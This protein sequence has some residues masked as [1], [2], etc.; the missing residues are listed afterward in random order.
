M[1]KHSVPSLSS[2]KIS[3][4]NRL[5]PINIYVHSISIA[6]CRS[7]ARDKIF[8]TEGQI[9]T[10]KINVSAETLYVPKQ[11]IEFSSP[12]YMDNR[13]PIQWTDFSDDL[14]TFYDIAFQYDPNAEN[15]TYI[16]DI[17]LL[18]IPEDY[19]GKD[20][21]KHTPLDE[22]DPLYDGVLCKYGYFLKEYKILNA[23]LGNML[24]GQCTKPADLNRIDI[25]KT[26]RANGN[27]IKNRG[28]I[29]CYH[30]NNG[31]IY[32]I[33]E[34]DILKNTSTEWVRANFPTMCDADILNIRKCEG[35]WEVTKRFRATSCERLGANIWGKNENPPG[36]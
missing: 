27:L 10:F 24:P 28:I 35:N 29:R 26:K 36:V 19:I 20:K 9:R 18:E 21:W 16:G 12:I 33:K 15:R 13:K 23:D 34:D 6:Y 17:V 31:S 11:T 3:D 7:H 25:V 30:W 1:A 8:D 5:L 14:Q 2:L 22:D 32:S 4:L